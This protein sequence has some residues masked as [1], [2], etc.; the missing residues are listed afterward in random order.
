VKLL[1]RA[2][3]RR[4]RKDDFFV[5]FEVAMFMKRL[6]SPLGLL[7]LSCLRALNYSLSGLLAL[8]GLHLLAWLLVLVVLAR[9]SMGLRLRVARMTS[10]LPLVMTSELPVA[11]SAV[12]STCA[13]MITTTM[14]EKKRRFALPRARPLAALCRW[15]WREST[16]LTRPCIVVFGT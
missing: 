11:V 15:C 5:S 1:F 10:V 2:S 6:L 16:W 9:R 14:T 4:C 12:M 7:L 8:P 3:L 13:K